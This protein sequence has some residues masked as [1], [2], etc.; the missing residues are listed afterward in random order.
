[1][2]EECVLNEYTH[3]SRIFYA[4]SSRRKPGDLRAYPVVTRILPG[5]L[6]NVYYKKFFITILLVL[7]FSMLFQTTE[8]WL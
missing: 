2:R 3:K 1:M 4:F 6:F 5:S 7:L 8:A